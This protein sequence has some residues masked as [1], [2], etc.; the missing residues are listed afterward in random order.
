L[1]AKINAALAALANGDTAGAAENVQGFIDHVNS[2]RGKKLSDDRA[3][4][5]V[6]AAV[7]I[8]EALE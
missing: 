2:Q 6:A 4:Q 3:D 1:V 8:L 7:E 5:L